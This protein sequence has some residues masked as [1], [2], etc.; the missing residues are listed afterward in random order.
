[1]SHSPRP[2]SPRVD[3]HHDRPRVV[4]TG[5]GLVTS[6]GH[7][8]EATWHNLRE[9]RIGARWL[10]TPAAKGQPPYAGYPLPDPDHARVDT[11]QRAAFEAFRD[12]RLDAGG[13]LPRFDPERAAVVVGFSKGDLRRLAAFHRK[14]LE[15]QA[16]TA[17]RGLRDM[18]WPHEP[19]MGIGEELGLVGP[20]LAPVAACATGVVAVLRA[21]DLIRRGD[22]D[23][24]LAGAGD[25]Q[26]EPL[27]LA[28]FR[29]MGALA[30]VA[31][32]PSAA[33]RPCDRR[34]SG[35]LPGEGSAVLVLEREDHALSRGARPYAEIVG[36]ALGAD[37][38]HI[39]GL[40][41]DPSHLA[42]LIRRALAH[43]AIGPESIDYINLH[44]TATRDN[45]P[46]ECRAIRLAFGE[47]AD[48]VSCSANKAQIGH[49]LGAAGAA[50]L[51]ITCLAIRDG[52]VPPTLNLTD[53]DPACDLDLNP[54][55]G[56]PRPIRAALKL[57]L[58]FGG[59]LAVAVLRSPGAL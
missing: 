48:G 34:R 57:S 14:L 36:G 11:I 58:G 49:L 26:L 52:F 39:T 38:S 43:A 15:G 20:R 6:L 12:A 13:G 21:A 3:R 42:G 51:A 35:F 22:C 45:D 5:V 30:Q 28:A 27:P 41:G 53:P 24:A 23:L 1:M 31:D 56:R 47:S 19:A 8:R 32:D 25:A 4:V 50:E 59:H 7:D 33:L 17:S 2:P 37:A 29:K 10:T 18:G 40:D 44:A 55:V 9:G 46:L 54:F 16:D